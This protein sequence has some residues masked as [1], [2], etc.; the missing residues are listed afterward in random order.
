MSTAR[1][2]KMRRE[3]RWWLREWRRARISERAGII[4]CTQTWFNVCMKEWVNAEI[5]SKLPVQCLDG[6]KVLLFTGIGNEKEKQVWGRWEAIM[7]LILNMLSVKYRRL[8][9]RR[10]FSTG[11]RSYR[12]K[13]KEVKYKPY[14]LWIGM[15]VWT[16]GV[17]SLKEKKRA[18]SM[19]KA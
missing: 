4:H 5:T 13:T 11:K 9:K 16:Y 17:F 19:E 15:S 6:R 18:V 12:Y 14:I 2:E 3:L 7:A 1:N 8:C 10:I